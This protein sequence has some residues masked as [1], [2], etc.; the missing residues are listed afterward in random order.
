MIFQLVYRSTAVRHL[1]PSDL[2]AML[3]R[4]RVNNERCGITGM[5][6]YQAGEFLQMLEGD[7]Q[8]VRERYDVIARDDRHKWVSLVLTS[9]TSK[10]D[11]PDWTMGFR[12]L[13]EGATPA[14]GWTAFLDEADLPASLPTVTNYIRD[15]FLSFRDGSE[16]R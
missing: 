3:T 10:R 8:A 12:D 13:E 5:L 9:P 11:F 15:I 16:C 2:L 6:L 14:R 7:E 4:S 1:D